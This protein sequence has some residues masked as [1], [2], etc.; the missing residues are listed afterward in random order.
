MCSK[1]EM[2]HDE[3]QRIDDARLALLVEYH[4]NTDDPEA[5]T[6][7]RGLVA[8]LVREREA[9]RR[10]RVAIHEVGHGNLG[11]SCDAEAGECSVCA[12]LD[13]PEHDALH[14]HH[15]GCPSCGTKWQDGPR[16]VEIDTSG[17]DGAW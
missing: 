7:E 11:D 2:M 14:Y 9:M 8:D 1:D 6:D 5:W 10:L 17:M 13:C 12:V 16:V 15:D 4:E 3:R